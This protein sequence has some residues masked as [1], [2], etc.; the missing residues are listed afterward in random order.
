MINRLVVTA[1]SAA[2][3]LS[4]SAGNLFPDDGI[5]QIVRVPRWQLVR[6]E[7]EGPMPEGL[8]ASSDRTLDPIWSVESSTSVPFGVNKGDL[9]AFTAVTDREHMVNFTEAVRAH[10]PKLCSQPIDSS[11]KST[12]LVHLGNIAWL[13]GETVKVDSATGGLLKDSPGREF[14][15][16]E[17]EKGWKLG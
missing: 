4:V 16:R 15:G 2:L 7:Q 1:A 8:R 9:V 14:W 17:Y 13:T 11:V 10:D 12:L 3:A 5:A 6:L